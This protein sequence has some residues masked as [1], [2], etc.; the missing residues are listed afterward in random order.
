MVSSGDNGK[1]HLDRAFV[2]AGGLKAG[3]W[4]SVG[5][6]ALLAIEAHR[7]PE[8]QALLDSARRTAAQLKAGSWES[9]RALA[10]LTRAEREVG[11]R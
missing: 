1:S 10:W 3:S 2:A 6:L 11:L 8:A 5:T 7:R 4:E 9:I